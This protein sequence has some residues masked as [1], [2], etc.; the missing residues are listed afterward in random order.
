MAKLSLIDNLCYHL[1]MSDFYGILPA[2]VTPLDDGESFRPD[3]YARLVER[4]YS[5]GVDGLYVCG[6]TGEG[7]Q[8][9]VLQRK[10]VAEESVRL[11]PRG[12]TVIVHVGAASTADALELTR[13][14]GRIGAHA[15]SSLPPAGN[16][17]F[18]EIREY[19]RA[20]AAASDVPLLVYY[21]PSISAAI[22]TTDQILELCELPNVAGLKFTDSDFFRLWA[23][24]QTGAVAFNGF[25]EMLIA[26]LIMGASGG[27]GSTYNLIP[28]TFVSLYKHAAAARWEEARRIQ[29]RINEFIAVVLH[30]P[31]QAA[32]KAILGWSG[33]DCG[34]CIAPRRPLTEQEESNL[35]ARIGATELGRDLLVAE[36]RG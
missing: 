29:D 17:S 30:Y 11:S 24:R 5:A 20:L 1:S 13:H 31:V 3:S 21:F 16:Y 25:D 26:G 22:R 34:K 12:K 23:I 18:G 15:I 27:I 6:Q 19:Y 8:Q 32:V 33:I 4:L 7:L 2:V 10:A 28:E 9:S 36:Q 35:Q 14:A